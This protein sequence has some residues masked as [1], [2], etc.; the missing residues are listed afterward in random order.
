MKRHRIILIFSLGLFCSCSQTPNKVDET[1]TKAL[2]NDTI[3]SVAKITTR[4]LH[5]VVRGHIDSKEYS[6]IVKSL[7]NLVDNLKYDSSFYCQGN[8]LYFIDKTKTVLDSIEL[9]EGC[10]GGLI[11]QDVTKQLKFT[12]PI[13]NVSS[14]SGSD[15]YTNEFIEFRNSR[16]KKLFEISEFGQPVALQRVDKNILTGFVKDRDELVYDFQDYPITVSLDNYEVRIEKP[17]KQH[18]GYVTVALEDFIGYRSVDKSERSK[19]LIKSGTTV[20]IDSLDRST[21]NVRL[22][23]SDTIFINVPFRDIKDKIQVNAAG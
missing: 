6:V 23:I 17:E 5:S 1:V 14:P 2:N 7:Y 13:F 11:I 4:K 15:Y 10:E 18:I 3:P 9:A 19:Y 22:I 8:Y 16:F 12:N 21:N 20:L